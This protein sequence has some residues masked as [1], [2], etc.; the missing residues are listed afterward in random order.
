MDGARVTFVWLG[1][2]A[3]RLVGDF[4][5]WQERPLPLAP[6][7]PGVWAAMH[8][9]EP[10]AYIE[11]C[12]WRG[13][14][15]V[16]DPLNPRT[17]PNGMG[18]TNHF[19]RLPPG[20]PTPLAALESGF[21]RGTVARYELPTHGL[22]FGRSRTL[23]LYCPPGAE[24]VPLWLVW[25]GQDY[26]ERGRLVAI[27][28]NLIA[29]QRIRPVALALLNHAGANRMAEYTCNEA[30][31]LFVHEALLPFARQHL[32]LVD[33]QAEPG[34]YGVLGASMGGLMALFTG[35][36]APGVFGH[37]LAQ[38]GAFELDG[39][40]PV[41]HDLVR[42][43]ARRGLKIWMDVGRYEWLLE[44][45]R[46]MRALLD[47]HGYAPVYREYPGGH[48]YTSWQNELPLGLEALLS[49]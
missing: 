16:T 7:G 25:D 11:Y 19:F 29:Q 4:T 8:D 26:L 49:K 10:G 43:H 47:Q 33:P 24:P 15:R 6:V 23:H 42:L 21:P 17:V 36:R 20:G 12:F 30:A 39:Y 28:D 14:R 13:G 32:D 2:K 46:R 9:F 18:Q 35:L 45:N 41:A 5:N 34:A 31:L 44:P 37:V 38:S 1:E 3:P 27:V 40:H 48:N 22:L